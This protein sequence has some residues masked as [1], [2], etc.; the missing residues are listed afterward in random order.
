V[1][2]PALPADGVADSQSPVEHQL[3]RALG[4]GV[5]IAIV[6]GNV[7][8][9]GI[10][11]KP[12]RIAADCG[13]FPLII[14]GWVLGG[15]ICLFGA[16]CF[17]ELAAMLP[18]AGGMYV[19]LREAYGRPVGFLFG[20]NEYVFGRT[21]TNGA[22]AVFFASLS[23]GLFLPPNLATHPWILAVVACLTI[24]LLTTINIVGVVWGG[25]VQSL[26]TIIKVGFLALIALLPFLFL[27]LDSHIVQ[28]S[29]Y[30][31]T[32]VP[33]KKIM[34]EQFAAILLSVMWAYN[35]WH[36]IAPVA[37][38]VRDPQRNIPL[39]L[40]GGTLLLMLLYVSVNVAYHGVLSM[41]QIAGAPGQTAQLTIQRT[42]RP[43]G[44]T[45]A[46]W[47]ANGITAVTLCSVFG[48]LNCNLMMGPRVAFAMARDRI[49][50]RPLAHVHPKFR[51]P[52]VSLLTQA[53][54]SC[55]LVVVGTY[56]LLHIDSLKNE[57][58]FGL[59]TNFVVYSANIFYALCVLGVYVLRI[60]HPEWTRPYHTWGYP[61]VP[62]LY[63]AGMGW[64][65][66]MA[67][68]AEPFSSG[69]GLALMALGL[70]VYGLISV[71]NMIRINRA[72]GE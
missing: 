6:V 71:W 60:R 3:L 49:F 34:S 29:N 44:E 4:P 21:A 54:M 31:T 23:C 14:T 24:S 67:Y 64:F 42:L 59:L 11:A 10:F 27:G 18:R 47:G 50:W 53:V 39:A 58:L 40:I 15:I 66:W 20:F 28:W 55:S 62:G 7:I 9:A 2:S 17:A 41:S 37:E 13:S 56:L 51:T 36:D 19:F 63:L 25:H 46:L 68:F 61:L 52:A 43:F 33:Q 48:A 22:L 35:G 5:A 8:G 45:W 16:L 70:P 12:S 65:L 26:T 57:D 32:V 69:V 30:L 1:S 38:E 72:L